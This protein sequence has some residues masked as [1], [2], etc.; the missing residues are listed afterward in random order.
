VVVFGVVGFL[1]KL[2]PGLKAA[3]GRVVAELWAPFA[4]GAGVFANVSAEGAS[5]PE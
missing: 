3:V 5:F 4:V 1:T 2:A